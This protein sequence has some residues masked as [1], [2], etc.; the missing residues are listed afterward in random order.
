MELNSRIQHVLAR[1]GDIRLAILFGSLV[2]RVHHI[3]SG[4]RYNNRHLRFIGMNPNDKILLLTTTQG[5]Q[6]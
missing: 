1:Y 2:D 6:A 3:R 5:P 4:C